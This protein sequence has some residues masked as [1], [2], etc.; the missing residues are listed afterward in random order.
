MPGNTYRSNYVSYTDYTGYINNYASGQIFNIIDQD[1]RYTL[2]EKTANILENL[3]R[4][5]DKKCEFLLKNLL[6]E[7][8]SE[9]KRFA[10]LLRKYLS[11]STTME[12]K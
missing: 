1:R 12:T 8:V 3:L 6:I 9:N 4:Y 7:L 5:R 2:S 11:Q 10:S